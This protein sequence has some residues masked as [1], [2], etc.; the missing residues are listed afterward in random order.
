ML[1]AEVILLL[2]LGPKTAAGAAIVQTD[3]CSPVH[4]A[5]EE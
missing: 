5:G 4:A 2:A 3:C 1:I